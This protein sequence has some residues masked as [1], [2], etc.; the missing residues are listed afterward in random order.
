[1]RDAPISRNNSMG[2][3]PNQ[4]DSSRATKT[5]RGRRGNCYVTSE[6]LFHLLGGRAAGW[7]AMRMQTEFDTHWFL[8]HESGLILDATK[9]QFGRETPD[10]NRAVGTGFLTRGPSKRAK[11]LMERMVWQD[12]KAKEA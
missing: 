8:K 9:S 7:K 5:I 12:G 6:S 11:L 3:R 10:Y 1:M 4:R 2:T